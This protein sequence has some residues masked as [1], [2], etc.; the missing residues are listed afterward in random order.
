MYLIGRDGTP[1]QG[2]FM[3][4]ILKLED[5]RILDAQFQTYPCPVS[6]T[7][8]NWVAEWVTGKTPEEAAGLQSGDIVAGVGR[9]P[10]GREHCPSLAINA[11]QDALR[12][13]QE[14]QPP[15]AMAAEGQGEQ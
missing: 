15:A 4:L 1:G 2:H 11:L 12:Q 10:L 3:L 5:N 13:I 6:H 8:G 7:C 9:M 14:E